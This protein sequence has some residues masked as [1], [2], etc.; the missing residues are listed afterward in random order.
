MIDVG[1]H[2]LQRPF[3]VEAADVHRSGGGGHFGPDVFHEVLVDG[4]TYFLRTQTIVG[5]DGESGFAGGAGGLG[6][7]SQSERADGGAL[8][9]VPFT[10]STDENDFFGSLLVAP[11]TSDER[12][13]LGEPE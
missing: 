13:V 9:P 4:E 7:V 12:L 2:D 8:G 10:D 5:M 1:V 6:A 3:S 11:G